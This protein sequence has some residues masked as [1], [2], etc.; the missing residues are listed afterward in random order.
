MGRERIIST[1]VV[2]AVEEMWSL[3]NDSFVPQGLNQFL[4][5]EERALLLHFLLLKELCIIIAL[6][7]L[8]GMMCGPWL[9]VGI[10]TNWSIIWSRATHPGQPVCTIKVSLNCT[11]PGLCVWHC[12][13]PVTS[14]G[15]PALCIPQ[16]FL[17]ACA[18]CSFPSL[19]QHVLLLLTEVQF[20]LK[21]T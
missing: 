19:C 8:P 12:L 18:A 6:S 4:W 20:P 11:V 1:S 14:V 13:L 15:S 17:P 7:L 9:E 21:K 10:E 16:D 5:D 2:T 3:Q